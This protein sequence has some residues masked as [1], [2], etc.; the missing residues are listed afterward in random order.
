MLTLVTTATPDYARPWIFS[1]LGMIGCRVV[2][3]L[4]PA[5]RRPLPIGVERHPY[6]TPGVLYQDGR[7]L[8][9]VPGVVDDDLVV[10]AD[11]DGVFQRDFSAEEVETLGGLGPMDFA[12]GYNVRP[13]QKGA[14]EYELLR[15]KQSL[16]D[17]ARSLDWAPFMMRGCWIYNTGLMAA[18]AA[19]WR[20]LRESYAEVFGSVNGGEFFRLHSWP[21]Y[22][23]CLTF[24]LHGFRVTELGY[25]VHS[26][27]HFPLTPKHRIERRQLYHDGNLVL[28]AHNVPG[29]CF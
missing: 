22:F 7:F 14:E 15:P 17:M 9:A 5:D 3:L 29:V 12:L 6:Q 20:R 19:T 10:L 11:A 28:F 21:Q 25:E 27:G 1:S 8:D 4:D 23:L 18:R 16:E 13:G 24:A 2:C 26:H